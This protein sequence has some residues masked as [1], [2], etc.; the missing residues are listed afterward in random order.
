MFYYYGRKKQIAHL[1]PKPIYDVIVEPFAG[2]AA[3]SLNSDNWEKQVYLRDASE[4]C[5]EIWK[6]LQQA[7]VGDII[8]LPK[9][10]IGD[11]LN[12]FKQLSKAE[13]YLIGVHINPGSSVPKRTATK[14]NRWEAGRKY[15]SLNLHK[16][17][18]WNIEL[19]NYT[20]AP[21]LQATWFIDPPYQT[22]GI[23]YQKTNL[24]YLDL[25]QY[26]LTRSGQII[27]CEGEG[28]S[29]LPFEHLGIVNNGGLNKAK[30]KSEVVFISNTQTSGLKTNAD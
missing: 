26:V 10:E 30:R 3:Y 5:I 6:Y 7:S 29:Y 16:I 11:S 8:S 24:N 17:K 14:A 21:N 12:N 9:L 20:D 28:A 23:Y 15:I 18:H 27:A 19:G 22:A 13:Q 1:Y 25:A 4:W 2:S